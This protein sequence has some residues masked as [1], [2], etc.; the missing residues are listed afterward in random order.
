VLNRTASS[1]ANAGAQASKRWGYW[2]HWY[3]VLVA[4]PIVAHSLAGAY[5][6]AA[7]AKVEPVLTQAVG[8]LRFV[9]I[10]IISPGFDGPL[11][12]QFYVDQI[13]LATWGVIL[14][15]AT[16]L[17]YALRGSSPIGNR[18]IAI[19]TLMRERGWSYRHA[20]ISIRGRL[21]LVLVPLIALCV[22]L[23][24]DSILGWIV[25]HFQPHD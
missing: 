19:D 9:G 24:L 14:C 12:R 16:T 20:W 7:L 5:R 4:A 22:A 2:I 13:G 1:D 15:T 8:A 25:F 21:F 17:L 3:A 6:P 11:G 18:D 10:R 23:F